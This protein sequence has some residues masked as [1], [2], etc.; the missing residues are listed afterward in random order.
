MN[1]AAILAG[2]IGTRMKRTDLPKQ[3]LMLGEKPIIIHTIEQF[4]ISGQIDRIII[5]TPKEWISYTEDIVGKYI[6]DSARIRITAGGGNRNE[7]IMNICNDIRAREGVQADDILITHDAVRPFITQRI[8]A[9]SIEALQTC[10]SAD[11]AIPAYDTIVESRDGLTIDSIPL[12]SSMYL[13][14]TPQTFRLE[15]FMTT[16]NDLDEA[17]KAILTDASKIYVLKGKS[18]AIVRGEAYNMKI[19]TSYDLQLAN[20]ILQTREVPQP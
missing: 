18:V 3:F 13:G 8:I 17:E 15:E 6:G 14:Q 11:T 9:D 20:L 4:F 2:G 12:R 7:T 5:G 10:D 1:Y 19:T 16:Y